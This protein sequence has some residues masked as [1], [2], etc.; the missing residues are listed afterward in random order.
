MKKIILPLIAVPIFLNSCYRDLGNYDYSDKE[1]ISIQGIESS[2]NVISLV[3]TLVITP[4]VTSNKN[5]EFEYFWYVYSQATP[6]ETDTISHD[7][8]LKYFVEKEGGAW[9]LVYGVINTLTGYTKLTD[10]EMNVG[11]TYTRGW[12]VLKDDGEYADIDQFLTPDT[13][14]PTDLV[15]NIHSSVN[16][17]KLLGKGKMISYYT[18]YRSFIADSSSAQ[19][20]KTLALITDN[21]LALDYVNT[22]QKIHGFDD[23]SYAVPEKRNPGF[24]G[25]S[26]N[27]RSFFL[28]NAGY[29]HSVNNSTLNAGLFGYQASRNSAN[30]DYDLSDYIVVGMYKNLFFDDMSSCFLAYQA[31]TNSFTNAAT[32]VSG[33]IKATDNNLEMIYMGLIQ[34]AESAPIIAYAKNKTDE[35]ERYIMQITGSATS[36]LKID[37]DTI[38]SEKKIFNATKLTCSQDERVIYFVLDNEVWTYNLSSKVEKLQFTAPAGETITLLRQ[39]KFSSPND[40]KFALNYVCVGTSDGSKYTVN[41]FTRNAGNLSADPDFKVEGDGYPRDIIYV[42]PEM[43]DASNLQGY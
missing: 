41:F 23:F 36:G 2:Y 7:K 26:K 14:V 37:A 15:A 40:I 29:L 42:S 1:E 18:T 10:V 19:Y 4:E 11:T 17:E 32:N 3:D 39:R 6:L 24:I 31:S 34:D 30:D 38:T 13:I 16:G 20:T 28:E 5:S 21:D 43:A 12:Y 22:M 35:T 27:S 8:N 33:E 9:T 25:Y